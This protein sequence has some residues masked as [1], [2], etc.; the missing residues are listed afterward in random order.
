MDG[1]RQMSYHIVFFFHFSFNTLRAVSEMRPPRVV[2]RCE[3]FRLARALTAI[4]QSVHTR[5]TRNM[6]CE[7]NHHSDEKTHTPESASVDLERRSVRPGEDDLEVFRDYRASCVVD[8]IL[9][10]RYASKGLCGEARPSCKR[11]L[12]A[13]SLHST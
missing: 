8:G 3:F 9:V 7:E 5:Y 11:T 10:S 12:N 4:G 6:I 1:C 2:V 13:R